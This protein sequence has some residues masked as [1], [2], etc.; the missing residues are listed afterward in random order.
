MNYVS[1]HAIAVWAAQRRVSRMPFFMQG[2]V[3]QAS[4]ENKYSRADSTSREHQI[5]PAPFKLAIAAAQYA[6]ALLHLSLAHELLSRAREAELSAHEGHAH[7]HEGHADAHEGHANAPARTRDGRVISLCNQRSPR[8][9]RNVAWRGMAVSAHCAHT[10]TDV[11]APVAVRLRSKP[12][13]IFSPL[14]FCQVRAT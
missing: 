9:R 5:G 1:A 7:A 12:R 2:R 4:S 8:Q 10:R 13:T 11:L 3:S 14:S 6:L